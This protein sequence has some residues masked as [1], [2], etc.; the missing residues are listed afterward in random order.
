MLLT[1]LTSK[2]R[3]LPNKNGKLG[4]EWKEYFTEEKQKILPIAQEAQILENEID[5]VV[6]ALYD[7]SPEEVKIVENE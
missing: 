5:A 1:L 6:Y 2:K 7:L 4:I 3:L